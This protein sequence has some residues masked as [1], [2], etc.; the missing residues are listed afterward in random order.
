MQVFFGT[1]HHS[2]S[3][4]EL[5]IQN[6]LQ[7][8]LVVSAPPKPLGRQQILTENP[9]V[10]MAK[11]LEIPVLTS[12]K[13][14]TIKQFNNLT[15]GVILDFNKIIPQSIIDLFKLGII[16]IHFSKLPH[17]R[18]PAPVQYTILNG[19]SEAWITYFLITAGLDDGPILKQTPL[20]LT[21]L[22][23]TANLYKLLLEKTSNDVTSIVSAYKDKLL[24]PKN[25]EGKPSFTRKLTTNAVK[26]DWSKSPI[27]IDRL[28]RAAYPEPGAWTEI[29]VNRESLTANR[30][31]L[32]ILRAHLENDQLVID[33]VQLEGKKPVSWKQFQ[34]GYPEA[35]IDKL[36]N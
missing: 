11:K 30:Q 8:D 19:E 18:G 17:Y 5:A 34:E 31:R 32:K 36:N 14:L 10:S 12:L 28:I 27:E 29:I 15:I 25:Q 3:F 24:L 13:D 16:N 1:S 33:L 23:S 6:G 35:K 7:V 26:I 9:T 2:A 21:G 22:E 20:P 4:L